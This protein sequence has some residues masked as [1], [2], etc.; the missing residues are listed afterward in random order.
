[1]AIETTQ[2]IINSPN[3]PVSPTSVGR[4]GEIAWDQNFKYT[5]LQDNPNGNLVSWARVAHSLLWE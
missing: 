5:C 2:L 4:Y 1:M 3:V